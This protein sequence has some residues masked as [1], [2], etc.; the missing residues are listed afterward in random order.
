MTDAETLRGL[1]GRPACW[2]PSARLTPPEQSS[3][4]ESSPGP[5]GDEE[6]ALGEAGGPARQLEAEW[7]PASLQTLDC[8]RLFL[9][10]FRV[11]LL[12]DR[13]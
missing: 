10:A 9:Q 8:A 11:H 5:L 6:A 12:L 7:G 4:G 2:H 3:K 1:A 13:H